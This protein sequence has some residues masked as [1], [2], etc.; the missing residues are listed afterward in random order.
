MYDVDAV[1]F[2]FE[3]GFRGMVFNV[4]ESYKTSIFNLNT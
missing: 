1:V 3:I 4:I 2:Y